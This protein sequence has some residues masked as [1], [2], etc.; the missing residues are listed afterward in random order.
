ME[1][2]GFSPDAAI[3]LFT[4]WTNRTGGARN[5]PDDTIDYMRAN[6]MQADRRN[7]LPPSDA[8]R[9]MGLSTAFQAAILDPKHESVRL[10]ESTTYWA[11]ETVT[12]HW[13]TL[14][15]LTSKLKAIA[16]RSRARKR[17]KLDVGSIFTPQQPQHSL[18]RQ[19]PQQ[20]VQI[21]QQPAP[22]QLPPPQPPTATVQSEIQ[23]LSEDLPF[24]AG[25]VQLVTTPPAALP[26]H[27]T[28]CKAKA[29][30]EMENWIEN[31]GSVNLDAIKTYGGGDFNPRKQAYYWTLEQATAEKYFQ[32]ARDRCQYS[33]IWMITVQVRKSFIDSLK[34][35]ELWYG[36]DWK[37]FVW[38]CRK[39]QF[40]PAKYEQYC[41]PGSIDIIKGHVCLLKDRYITTVP[42]NQFQTFINEGCVMNMPNGR[43]STQW[44]FV[45]DDS[46]ARFGLEIRGKIHID[47][48]S[49][50]IS[51]K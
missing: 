26:E 1:W 22:P 35:V 47:I 14:L 42:N 32:Y 39:K 11:M 4:R 27:Y 43:K 29:A 40:P 16:T 2:C 15:R 45:Q 21:Q 46:S 25:Q 10:T 33:E 48:T 51:F 12:I 28:L 17:A 20:Q 3:E 38:Y 34:S 41:N 44:A 19:Q 31:D 6:I 37:E 24:P 9:R 13:K 30:V 23:G 49:P 8:M 7:D 18:P 36:H 5:N 50:A